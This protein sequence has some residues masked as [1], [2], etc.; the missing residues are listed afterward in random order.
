MRSNLSVAIAVIL[1]LILVISG[2][3]T[4]PGPEVE[5]QAPDVP[6]LTEVGSK[7]GLEIGNL[8]P[9]FTL[10]TIDGQSVTLSDFR[11]KM[12]MLVFWVMECKECIRELPHIQAIFDE[13]LSV[14]LAVLTVNVNNAVTEVQEFVDTNKYTFPVLLD[15]DAEVCIKYRHGAPTTFF[16][17]ANGIIRE[18]RDET[19]ESRDEIGGI[20]QSLGVD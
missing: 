3:A 19:F 11:G 14:K 7:V 16:I 8:A 12:V 9:D 13:A 15:L 6:K 10:Q 18:I 1:S 5:E 17:D 4:P 20:L 2:C